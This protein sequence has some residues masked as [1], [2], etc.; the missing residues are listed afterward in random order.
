MADEKPREAQISSKRD[1]YW[2]KVRG[3]DGLVGENHLGKLLMKLRDELLGECNEHLR[4]V[5]PPEQLNLRFLGMEIRVKDRRNHL[6]RVGTST[7]AQV[8]EVRP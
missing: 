5:S 6:R 1:T 3:D 8:N 7:S 4:V 2:G